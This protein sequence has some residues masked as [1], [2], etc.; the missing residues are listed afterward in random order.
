MKPITP[1]RS[2]VATLFLLAA[3]FVAGQGSDTTSLRVYRSLNSAL[4]QPDSV[5]SLDLS[6]QHFGKVPEEIFRFKNLQE[7]RMRNDDLTMLPSGIGALSHLRL[8]DLSGNPISLLP[9]GFANLSELEEL[10][11]SNDSALALRRDISILA[12]LPR[13]HVLHLENDGLR[14]LP[15]NIGDLRSL[16]ELYLNGNAF[17]TVPIELRRLDHIRLIDMHQNPID[18]LIPL[19]LQQRGV[20]IR[21]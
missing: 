10:Y 8:L 5:L 11:L 4:L 17:R 2:F 18:P 19:D 16:E 9:D 20:L 6:D 12:K 21:F 3:M 13:L 1:L 15:K 7:L 14:D